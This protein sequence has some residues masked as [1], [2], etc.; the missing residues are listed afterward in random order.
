[1]SARFD[2]WVPCRVYGQHGRP[3]V[4]WC[5]LGED[6][7]T[8]P[9]FEDTIRRALRRPFNLLFRH[10]TPIDVLGEWRAVQPGLAPTGFIFHM[11]R[12]GST[13]IARV[14][15]ALPRHVV[16]SEA[17]PIDA[18]L[19]ANFHDGTA[20]PD[21]TDD[22]RVSW[23]QWMISAL[24]QRRRGDE[25]H[26]FVKF[27]S[28]SAL[29]LPLVARAFPSV[30]WIFVYRNPVDVIMSHVK[31][32]GAQMVSAL[33]EPELFQMDRATA[34]ELPFEEY[35]ARVLASICRAALAPLRAGAGLAVDYVEL[36]DAIWSSLPQYWGFDV[37]A[38]DRDTMKEAARYDA[39]RPQFLFADD[40]AATPRGATIL[41]RQ[42]ADAWM[43]PLYEELKAL[44][45]VARA[46]TAQAEWRARSGRSPS[47]G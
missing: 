22:R 25:G 20:A 23:L 27:D 35:A 33:V 18:V 42:V 30:P 41:A 13:L 10:Q 40:T 5:Y 47:R 31:H 36:P 6:G 12:C 46:E 16:I 26:F 39:K 1:M 37:T 38:A 29:S 19:R 3:S 45:H 28:W 43:G 8:E 44:T 4:D 15:A 14:L 11:S 17:G 32:R 21:G 24:G 7:F 9:F 2:G 34:I